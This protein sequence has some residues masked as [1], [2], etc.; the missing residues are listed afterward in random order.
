LQSL[1]GQWVLAKGAD[2]MK[3]W[4]DTYFA[5]RGY[6]VTKAFA[7]PHAIQ[8]SSA[9]QKKHRARTTF[10]QTRTRSAQQMR[11]ALHIHVLPSRRQIFSM[12]ICLCVCPR[13]VLVTNSAGMMHIIAFTRQLSNQVQFR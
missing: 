3:G 13:H 2:T 4:G 12:P 10:A 1:K 6:A 8:T 9:S 7:L 5:N 11:I